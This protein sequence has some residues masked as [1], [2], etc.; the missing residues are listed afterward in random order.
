MGQAVSAPD[1]VTGAP[2]PPDVTDWL[3]HFY[4]ASLQADEPL[5]LAVSGGADSMAMLHMALG[6]AALRGRSEKV[7]TIIIDHALRQGSDIEAKLTAKRVID[8]G[9]RAIIR[10]WEHSG[11]KSAIQERARHA[12][13]DLLA[14]SCYDIGASRLLVGHTQDDQAETI[15]MR[16]RSGASWRGLA[17]I[18]D[19]IHAPL[20]PQTRHLTIGRPLLNVSRQQT[21]A[22][23]QDNGVAFFDD[24]SNEDTDYQRV[25]VRQALSGDSER[26]GSLLALGQ[27][28][29]ARRGKE[30]R[31]VKSW[32]SREVTLTDYGRAEITQNALTDMPLAALADMARF[33]GG[34]SYRADMAQVQALRDHIAAPDFAARTL[35]GSLFYA[36]PD[37]GA[38]DETIGVVRDPGG[39]LG[40]REKA[41]AM[42]ELTPNR[43][44]VWDGRFE[45]ETSRTGVHMAALWPARGQLD[46]RA[47]QR[48]GAIASPARRTLPAF[49][50]GDTLLAA[51]HLQYCAARPSE[52]YLSYI[53]FMRF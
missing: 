3:D 49:F 17:G 4:H 10:T 14:R 35:G 29:R 5:A 42:L 28:M 53:G 32:L 21:R 19:I 11:V 50:K 36:V 26:R 39:V 44:A 12:R 27:E 34:Q 33:M 22:Y 15:A 37:R 8:M 24:P 7:Y 45:V 46:K 47:K 2:P 1:K 30:A 18:S 6:W 40:R 13:Y 43:L 23:C 41:A 25:S 9:A 20:W 51:P 48:L 38:N 31:A 16:Q 52:F